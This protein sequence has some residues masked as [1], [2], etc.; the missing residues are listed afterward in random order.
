MTTLGCSPRTRGD[1]RCWPPHPSTS[2]CSPRTRGNPVTYREPKPA[3]C[4]SAHAG[5]PDPERWPDIEGS[6]SPH[7]R[8]DPDGRY[9]DEYKALCSRARG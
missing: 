7:T 6:C 9:G 5:D 1:P 3:L 2:C 8:V 4:C